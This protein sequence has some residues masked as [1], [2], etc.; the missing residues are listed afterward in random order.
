MIDTSQRGGT[1]ITT[2]S[3]SEYGEWSPLLT[4]INSKALIERVG[5]K[6]QVDRADI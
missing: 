2:V 3:I 5:Y 4:R 6:C 1:L